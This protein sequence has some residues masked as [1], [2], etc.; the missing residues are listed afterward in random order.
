[1]SGANN[2]DSLTPEISRRRP[3]LI[4]LLVSIL[5]GCLLALNKIAPAEDQ[6][7]T[8]SLADAIKHAQNGAQLHIFYVHGI[9]INPPKPATQDFKTSEEF[10]KSFC[11]ISK[12]CNPDS[13]VQEKRDYASV[14]DFAIDAPA[15]KLAYLG[16]NLWTDEEWRAA[17]PFVD[18]YKNTLKDGSVIYVDEINWWPLVL[19]PKCRKIVDREA[20]F[21]GPDAQHID[22]CSVKTEHDPADKERFESFQWLTNDDQL[23]QLPAKGAK[24][25]RGLK[26]DLMDW[27]FADALMA[28]GP[29]KPLFLE[30]IH[31]LILASVRISSDGTR[32]QDVTPALNQEFVVVSHSL[33]SYLMFSALDPQNL[34]GA[35][36]PR[37]KV[38]FETVLG[39]T[40]HAYFLANQIRLLELANLDD[41]SNQQKANLLTHL[42]AW[43]EA[44]RKHSQPPPA[45]IAFGDPSDLLTFQVPETGTVPICNQSVKNA[46]HWFWYFE[47]PASAHLKYD[48]N[49]SAMRVIVPKPSELGSPANPGSAP[50]SSL[51]NHN[52]GPSSGN[53]SAD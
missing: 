53:P 12:E 7:V 15:P 50:P 39:Q 33:G 21:I 20:R 44:R 45:I 10:R 42:Q 1:M 35:A 13:W 5:L 46:W 4:A 41:T 36:P 23:K 22:I 31:E 37:W 34:T 19:G 25:N 40:S 17:A 52:C 6:S 8:A 32:G 29:M 9:G 3:K 27:G 11:N 43:A 16:K 2:R 28:V 24:F 26:A 47:S 18:H 48:L 14:G 51:L 49:K 30:A 38:D